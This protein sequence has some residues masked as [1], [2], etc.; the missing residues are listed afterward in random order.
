MFGQG[1]KVTASLQASAE[2]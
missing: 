1:I 2:V